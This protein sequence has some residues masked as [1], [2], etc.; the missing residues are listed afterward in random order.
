MTKREEGGGVE[1]GGEARSATEVMCSGQRH[2]LWSLH[3]NTCQTLC[4][5]YSAL[6]AKVNVRG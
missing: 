6:E 1:A 2:V 4:L 3:W 5:V